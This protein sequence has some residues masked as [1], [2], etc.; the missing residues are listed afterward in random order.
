[1][2][3]LLLA[4]KGLARVPMLALCVVQQRL[5]TGLLPC[6]HTLVCALQARPCWQEVCLGTCSYGDG[7]SICTQTPPGS[8]SLKSYPNFHAVLQFMMAICGLQDVCLGSCT[9]S[10][11]GGFNIFVGAPGGSPAG[12]AGFAQR[13][14]AGGCQLCAA[15][16]PATYQ[17]GQRQASTEEGLFLDSSITCARYTYA[18]LKLAT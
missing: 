17:A 9:C 8:Q 16:R 3:G 2:Q 13:A 5:D 11:A 6:V 18:P 7:F 12:R 10:H 1:M 15:L 4:Y 14:H